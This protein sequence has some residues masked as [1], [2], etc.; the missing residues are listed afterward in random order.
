MN[1]HP[2]TALGFLMNDIVTVAKK[3]KLRC[4]VRGVD[5]CHV[6]AGL[7]LHNVEDDS[8]NDVFEASFPSGTKSLQVKSE[9]V[10]IEFTLFA[11]PDGSVFWIRAS[12]EHHPLRSLEAVSA[13][14][15]LLTFSELP[16]EFNGRVKA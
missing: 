4:R 3:F 1:C 15:L 8:H 5:H 16:N 7:T 2:P 10:G 11:L 12:T 14:R 6:A 9:L 13:D